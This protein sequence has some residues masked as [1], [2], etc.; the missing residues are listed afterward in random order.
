MGDLVVGKGEAVPFF[1]Q[2]NDAPDGWRY[3]QSSSIVLDLAH[4]WVEAIFL[5]EF[6]AY[7][8]GLVTARRPMPLQQLGRPGLHFRSVLK[9]KSRS[10][11]VAATKLSS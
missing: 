9:T 11:L 1:E 7:G 10:G 5:A 2:A 6:I 4:L 8:A 3:C